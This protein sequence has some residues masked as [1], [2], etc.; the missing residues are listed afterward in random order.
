MKKN[1]Y[2]V[3]GDILNIRKLLEVEEDIWITGLT[4]DYKEVE[5]GYLF[6]A[7]KGFYQDHFNY[8]E[9]AIERGIK[10]YERMVEPLFRKASKGGTVGS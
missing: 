7:T 9:K 8:I 1:T 2:S 6:V 3:L 5:D 10:K 4:E